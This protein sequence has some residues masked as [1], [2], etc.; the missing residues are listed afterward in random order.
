MDD[1]TP[2]RDAQLFRI[3]GLIT[4]L[5]LAAMY[6]VKLPLEILWDV[7]AEG[8]FSFGWLL[9]GLIAIPGTGLTFTLGL[10]A[11]GAIREY[12][13]AAR[14]DNGRARQA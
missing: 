13:T 6:L 3:L 14:D 11:L 12:L 7:P 10:V 9:A 1:P 5:I 4:L 2:R 8:E